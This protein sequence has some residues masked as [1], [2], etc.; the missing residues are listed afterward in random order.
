MVYSELVPASQAE[1]LPNLARVSIVNTEPPVN[2]NEIFW[3]VPAGLMQKLT[4][5]SRLSTVTLLSSTSPSRYI[6]SELATLYTG[7]WMTSLSQVFACHATLA[8][9]VAVLKPIAPL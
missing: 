6:V 9:S 7:L 5:W 2:V 3:K 8:V 1:L 4:F